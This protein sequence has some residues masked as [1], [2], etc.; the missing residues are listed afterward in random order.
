MVPWA[1]SQGR[2]G[3]LV[4]A[5]IR[6][7]VRD[8]EWRMSVGRRILGLRS[9]AAGALTN[10]SG[11]ALE[12]DKMG[13]GALLVT[14]SGAMGWAAAALLRVPF[15]SWSPSL[16]A[17]RGCHISSLRCQGI[18]P[19]CAWQRQA[20]FRFLPTSTRP[21]SSPRHTP[22]FLPIHTLP[23]CPTPPISMGTAFDLPSSL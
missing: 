18:V 15:G 16:K 19:L 4:M 9:L 3:A 10:H 7:G 2:A 11:A 22:A 1:P 20:P 12:A 21:A 14:S 5:Q 23:S 13:V 17:G 8:K 6:I